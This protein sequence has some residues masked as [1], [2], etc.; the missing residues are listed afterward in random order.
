MRVYLLLML[1][2]L[3]ATVILTPA[4]RRLALMFNVLTPLRERDVHIVPTP[5]MGGVAITA[6]FGMALALGY[7]VEFLRPIYDGN[8]IW[9]VLGGAVMICV[10]GA[11]DDVWE[12]DWMAKLGG[13][14]I[15]TGWMALNGVQLISFPIFG[16]TIGS[17][18]LSV[19]VSILVMVTV[20]NAVNFIDG[21]DGLAAGVIAIGAGSFFI[22]SYL[23]SRLMDAQTYATAAAVI[24]VALVGASIGF[25]WYN[26]H[27]ASIFMGDSG[28][29]VLGLVMSAAA[30]IVTGQVNP[31]VLGDHA[32]VASLLPLLL[33]LVVIAIPLVD[34]VLT[35]ATRILQGKSPFV[36]DRTHLHDRLLDVGHSHRGVVTILYAWTLLASGVGIALLVFPMG[37]VLLVG[38][39]LAAVLVAASRYVFPGAARRKKSVERGGGVPG[40]TILVDDGI[41]VISRPRLPLRATL[42]SGLRWEPVGEDRP[43]PEDESPTTLTWL[44]I[45]PDEKPADATNGVA[46]ASQQFDQESSQ[47]ENDPQ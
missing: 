24:M 19:I 23:L 46:N 17:A 37:R 15:V 30:I 38:L 28:A 20:I 5:R 31:R 36:A 25:L 10:L 3:G 4:V 2:A 9:I 44:E 39:G 33:P 22:Y 1:F 43:G 34:L 8:I 40:G 27:P 29:M 14:I 26:F 45:A 16:L 13:Q 42:S 11:V 6:G 32:A 7:R 21:L 35:A 47:K 18:R 12:L 41:A